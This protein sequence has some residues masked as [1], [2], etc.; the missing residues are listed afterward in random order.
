MTVKRSSSSVRSPKAGGKYTVHVPNMMDI[1][2]DVGQLTKQITKSQST[3]RDKVKKEMQPGGDYNAVA[4][5]Q[6]YIEDSGS[7]GKLSS[8][9]AFRA[10]KL[11][12]SIPEK[13]GNDPTVAYIRNLSKP[14]GLSSKSNLHKLEV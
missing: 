13:G 2:P 1:G 3:L 4:K 6:V 10:N 9:S 12:P 14:R 7:E 8:A 5:D 11:L